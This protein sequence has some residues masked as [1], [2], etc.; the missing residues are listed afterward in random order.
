MQNALMLVFNATIAVATVAYVILTRRLWRATKQSADAAKASADAAKLSADAANVTAD[1][2]KLSADAASVTA[3]AARRSADLGAALHRPHLGVSLFQR[4]NA[5]DAEQWA[6]R[7]CVRNYGTLAGREVRVE[8]AIDRDG[9]GDF[10]RGMVCAGWEIPPGAEVGGFLVIRMDRTTRE[11]LP[12]GEAGMAGHVEVNYAAPDGRSFT[13][14]ADFTYDR[15]TQDFRPER[16][17]TVAR[18]G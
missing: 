12:K 16:S 17:E 11:L 18:N 10:G 15:T 13:H 7:C 3:D 1:A 9:R 2:A 8:V 14:S 4:H 5:Y 6:I